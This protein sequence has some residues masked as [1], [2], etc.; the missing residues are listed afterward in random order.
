MNS[1]SADQ[2]QTA[3]ATAPREKRV[4]SG[5]LL[6]L[7]A[8][9]PSLV[10]AGAAVYAILQTGERYSELREAEIR[11]QASLVILNVRESVDQVMVQNRSPRPIRNVAL[12][13]VLDN[14][15]RVQYVSARY[16]GP[17]ERA[18]WRTS[19]DRPVDPVVV[20]YS[21][22]DQERWRLNG[23]FRLTHLSSP[24][25]Q[26]EGVFEPPDPRDWELAKQPI[27]ACPGLA[28]Y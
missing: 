25:N 1:E 24:E 27:K 22:Y 8:T 26:G 11:S 13:G 12:F 18:V 3:S 7:F 15:R 17:C 5:F 19:G 23:A 14:G 16:V 2:E 20:H 4:I 28:R 9:V 10:V 21:T 6:A